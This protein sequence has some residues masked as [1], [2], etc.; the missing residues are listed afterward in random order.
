M[1]DKKRIICFGDSNT[2]GY[3]P[4]PYFGG[5]YQENAIWTKLLEKSGYE[6]VNLGMNGRCIPS[7]EYQARAAM[8]CIQSFKPFN[9]L[10]IMLGTNDLLGGRT[11]R[12]EQVAARMSA[13]L[14]FIIDSMGEIK[15]LLI[16]PPVLKPGEW[17]TDGRLTSE[18]ARLG[19]LYRIAADN[20]GAD[21]A[22]A[23][24]WDIE[25]AF[26][27]VHFTENGHARFAEKLAEKLSE[28]L[29]H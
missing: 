21:Y 7:S 24:A 8:E 26:D 28:K 2:Y 17:V 16:S 29:L 5:R 13:F 15:I 6:A 12:A 1:D 19:G 9:L 11:I 3:D 10:T 20:A 22:D 27:G 18:S 14:N 23:A 4:R 25:T